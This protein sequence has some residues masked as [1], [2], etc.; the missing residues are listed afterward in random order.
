M[1]VSGAQTVSTAYLRQA[2]LPSHL[3]SVPHDAAPVS[4]HLP[5]GS[6]APRATFLHWPSEL[7]SE[8]L[9]QAPV[10]A[11]SQ[12]TPS[13]HWPELHCAAVVQGEPINFL[14]HDPFTQTLGAT[15]WASVVQVF[16]QPSPRHMKG[17]HSI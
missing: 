5:W 9:W 10:Q 7:C 4:L 11:V 16:T 15:H 8:Q 17:A 1:Q 13:T 3:P 12:Q 14:P 6:M 2:P